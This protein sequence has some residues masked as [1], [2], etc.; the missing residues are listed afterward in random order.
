MRYELYVEG[1]NLC[2]DVA[3]HDRRM[4]KDEDDER[5]RILLAELDGEIVG[6]GAARRVAWLAVHKI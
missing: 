3:D 1:R 5:G 6:T 4:L 2:T